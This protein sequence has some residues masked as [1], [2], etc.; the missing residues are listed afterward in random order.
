MITGNFSGNPQCGSSLPLFP[1][2]FEYRKA[3]GLRH[4]KWIFKIEE[5]KIPQ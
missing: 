2:R 1:D 5:R 3:P 4:F